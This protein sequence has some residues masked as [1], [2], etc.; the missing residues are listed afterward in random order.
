MGITQI[1]CISLMEEQMPN[2]VL[3]NNIE[4]G[5]VAGSAVYGLSNLY[6]ILGIIILVLDLVL[7]AFKVY[8]AISDA[9]KNK[10]A[11]AVEQAIK[12]AQEGIETL[13]EAIKPK[14]EDNGDTKRTE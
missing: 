6:T 8:Q 4:V 2:K 5:V 10:D 14:G 11:G 7:I 13:Q 9:L 1:A 12:D 3:M